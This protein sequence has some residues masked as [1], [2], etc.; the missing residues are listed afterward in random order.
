MTKL[1]RWRHVSD[2]QEEGRGQGRDRE[3]DA[4]GYKREN[5]FQEK[6]LMELFCILTVVIWIYTHN[7][8]T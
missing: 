2:F 1:Y 8:V 5:P 3:W 4:C 6:S 7:N